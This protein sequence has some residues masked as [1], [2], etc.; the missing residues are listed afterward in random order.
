MDSRI[1]RDFEEMT[2]GFEWYQKGETQGHYKKE[3]KANCNYSMMLLE[4]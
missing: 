2:G 4:I 1:K 3:W